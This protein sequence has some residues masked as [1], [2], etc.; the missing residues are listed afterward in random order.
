MVSTPVVDDSA[1][2]TV[3]DTETIVEEYKGTPS[4]FRK[5]K[6]EI[7]SLRAE[8][9]HLKNRVIRDILQTWN[10][11]EFMIMGA[12]FLV[13]LIILLISAF[14]ILP[15][16]AELIETWNPDFF[17]WKRVETVPTNGGSENRLV[18]YTPFMW[19]VVTAADILRYAI[20]LFGA[21]FAIISIIVRL[22]MKPQVI[23]FRDKVNT[24]A[25]GMTYVF[26]TSQ[27]AEA[28][29]NE[30]IHLY[31]HEEWMVHIADRSFLWVAGNTA[32]VDTYV[33][34]NPEEFARPNLYELLG[35][36]N[37]ERILILTE[38]PELNQNILTFVRGQTDAEIIM[39]EQFA[40][41]FLKLR[42]VKDPKIKLVDDVKAI[43]ENL[44]LSMSLDI[45]FPKC[46]ELNAPRTHLGMPASNMNCDIDGIEVLKVKRDGEYLDPDTIL[47][48]GDRLLVYVTVPFDFK[49]TARIT[50]QLPTKD[51]SKKRRRSA[52]R[53]EENSLERAKEDQ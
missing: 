11:Q 35:F 49:R 15:I 12:I 53:S 7:A 13:L 29:L 3:E 17:D 8:I 24:R 1:K 23:K 45:R 27:Y 2:S 51:R 5:I 47:Q 30:V 16:L 44:I 10:M 31:G 32:F 39:L 18:E 38:D 33:V 48:V 46:L 9:Y 21:A 43:T 14:L 28:F 26:G 50:V 22:R 25:S 52:K 6:F 42:V 19:V 41:A 40:P 20:Y 37:A 34:E 4:L 36:K